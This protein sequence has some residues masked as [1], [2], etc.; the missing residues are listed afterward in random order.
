[1]IS[2]KQQ[3]LVLQLYA[4]YLSFV[5]LSPEVYS[6]SE[7]LGKFTNKKELTDLV[8]KDVSGILRQRNTF[9]LCRTPQLRF[10]DN[11]VRHVS[12]VANVPLHKL[13]KEFECDGSELTVSTFCCHLD[14][15][16]LRYP[17]VF[18]PVFIRFSNYSYVCT[19]S[20]PEYILGVQYNKRKNKS[21][22]IMS[23]TNL[24]TIDW[25]A[26]PLSQVREYISKSN[27]SFAVYQTH[28]GYHGYCISKVYPHDN[29]MS[30]Q[31]MFQLG[32][33]PVYISFVYYTGYVIR[34]QPKKGRNEPFVE[35]Y[36]ETIH[37]SSSPAL[38]HLQHLVK[39][40]DNLISIVSETHNE[41]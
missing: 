35:K 41:H 12:Q 40:K 38:P 10:F 18:I 16:K 4:Q 34:L 37:N 1:M 13:Y 31:T 28:N 17:Q 25:D 14:T 23:F 30:L 26:M 7:F 2:D 29:L 11:V 36:I 6:L 9:T 27:E 32:C 24:M 33:D 8:H 15:L 22:E 5:K 21:L 3:N 20:T 19:Q 39:I